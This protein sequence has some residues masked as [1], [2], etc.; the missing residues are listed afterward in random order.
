MHHKSKQRRQKAWGDGVAPSGYGSTQTTY[1]CTPEKVCDT[2]AMVSESWD[3]RT[4]AYEGGISDRRHYP[5]YFPPD[6]DI[7]T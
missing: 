5:I 2:V 7:Q 4:H 3:Y 1:T 6:T